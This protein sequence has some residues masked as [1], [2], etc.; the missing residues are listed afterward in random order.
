MGFATIHVA[1]GMTKRKEANILRTQKVGV[2]D[3]AVA[4]T[5]LLDSGTAVALQTVADTFET[6][7]VK[8][9]MADPLTNRMDLCY[10]KSG[11]NHYSRR[12]PLHI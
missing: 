9:E 3:S 1:D 6:I 10:L 2:A 8:S 4:D 12:Q 5:T 7:L 11:E